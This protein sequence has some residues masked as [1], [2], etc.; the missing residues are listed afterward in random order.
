[1]QNDKP[2]RSTSEKFEI[3]AQVGSMVLGSLVSAI[4]IFRLIRGDAAKA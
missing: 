1:M 3:A 4:Q 2:T